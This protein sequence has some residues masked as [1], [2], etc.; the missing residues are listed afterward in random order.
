MNVIIMTKD[1][2]TSDGRYLRLP[3]HPTITPEQISTLVDQFYQRVHTSELLAPIFEQQTAEDWEKH[4]EKMK[5]FWRSVLLRTGEYK[6]KP[7]P[8]HQRLQGITT[9]HFDE[10]LNLFSITSAE[11]F[12]SEAVPLVEAAA[13]RIATSL[14]LSR[15]NDPFATPPTWSSDG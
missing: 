13:R 11:V 1:S 9:R 14:W 7:V 8:V 5:A 4:L 3:I 10:W 15:S 6:G 12:L 2:S